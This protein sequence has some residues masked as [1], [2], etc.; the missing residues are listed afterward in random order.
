MDNRLNIRRIVGALLAVASTS[1][2]ALDVAIPAIG[3]TLPTVPVVGPSLPALPALPA[4]PIP[5]A[6]LA[7]AHSFE[8]PVNPDVTLPAPATSPVSADQKIS[9]ALTGGIGGG[10]AVKPGKVSVRGVYAS[11]AVP[12]VPGAPAAPLPTLPTPELLS[13]AV[14]LVNGLPVPALPAGAPALPGLPLP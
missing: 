13:T 11:T 6:P 10:H 4:L 9:V 2:L 14:T 1:A 5:S 7:T 12:S 8:L 3:T